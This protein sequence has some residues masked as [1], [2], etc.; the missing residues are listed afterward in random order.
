[1]VGVAF[2]FFLFGFWEGGGEVT[3][4]VRGAYGAITV[5]A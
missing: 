4:I 1:M 3:G 2:S 5:K